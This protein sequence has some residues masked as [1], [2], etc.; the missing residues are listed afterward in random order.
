[1]VELVQKIH[2][3]DSH[4]ENRNM[5][6][7]NKKNPFIQYHDGVKWMYERK[8]KV[9]DRVIDNSHSIMQDHFDEHEGKIKSEMSP[10]MY[11]CIK[12]WLE[13]V[14][15]RDQKEVQ[16]LYTD[17]YLMILNSSVHAS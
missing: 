14:G 17:L 8:N 6:I 11:E 15:D 3:D 9:L 10:T 4:S 13:K 16:E 1:M 12:D 2:Y 5:R 7:T